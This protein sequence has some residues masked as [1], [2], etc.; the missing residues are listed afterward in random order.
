MNTTEANE[1]I[2]LSVDLKTL[3]N[4]LSLV[5]PGKHIDL[6]VSNAHLTIEYNNAETSC[7]HVIKLKAKAVKVRYYDVND[8]YQAQITIDQ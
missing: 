7:Q 5:D 1:D 3:D 6:Q 2:A 8:N 4:V